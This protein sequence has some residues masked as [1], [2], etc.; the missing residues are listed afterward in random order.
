MNYTL[1]DIYEDYN[2]SVTDNIP[3]NIFRNI[4]VEFNISIIDYILEGKIFNM[5]NNLSSLSVIRLNRN[6][7]SPGVDWIESNSYKKELLDKGEKLYDSIT[8]LGAKWLIYYTDPEYCKYHWNKGNCKIP[9]KFAY[10]FT[11]T[12]GIKGN[13]DKLASLL[14]DDDLAYLKFKKHI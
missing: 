3:Q 8:N 6:P 4:C 9:N 2:T 7:K 5:K 10:R 1:K 13:K 11:P 14:K 12:R